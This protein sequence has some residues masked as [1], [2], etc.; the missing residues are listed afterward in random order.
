MNIVEQIKPFI[1]PR[2]IA[3]VGVSSRIGKYSF[4]IL[5]N[6]LDIGYK[7]EIYPVNPGTTDILGKKTYPNITEIDADIDLAI[8]STPRSQVLDIV[9]ECIKKEIKAVIIIGQGFADANDEEGK[10]LQ[11]KITR[12]IKDSDTRII[13][14]NTIG[15]SNPF[16]DFSTSFV[17]QPCMKRLPIGV[18]C[19]T[20]MFF[21]S[22]PNLN[23]LGKGIDLGN[24][25][26][27]DFA[28]CLE[29]FEYDKDIEIIFLHIEGIRNGKKFID[30]AKR[31]SRKK[32]ILALK[33][34]VY[35]RSAKAAQSHT[36]SIIGKDEIWE[37]A[38]KQCGIVR[39]SDFDEIDDLINAFSNL[40]LMKGRSVG[41]ISLSGGIGLM[42]RDAC[43]EYN[44]NIPELSSKTKEK[45]TGISPK[46]HTINNPVDIWPAM[47]ISKKP[48]GEVLGTT[49]EAFLA[50]EQ[51][52]AVLL[53]VGAWFESISPPFSEILLSIADKFK[54]KPIVWMPYEGWLYDIT[55]KEIKE[56]IK[57]HRKVAVFSSP[58]RA[59]NAL[60]KLAQYSEFLSKNGN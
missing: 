24:T 48:F 40:P 13:G 52:D 60:S 49:I 15:V 22:F 14:P 3:L 56:N 35:P 36:G 45:I 20:G 47:M 57:E 43:E 41:I 51:I 12:L 53:I 16:I 19:Q 33:T 10:E 2:S 55:A 31:V 23:I 37:K 1:E 27:L 38:L 39:I 7:G 50:D 5:E 18:I 29:Y 21:G 58:K 32:P 30:V 17:K 44:L 54:D 9:K 26:D 25:C 59:L 46:W 4:N 8:I 11:K 6:I 42:A 34:G 28:D